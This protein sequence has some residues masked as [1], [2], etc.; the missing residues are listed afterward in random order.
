MTPRSFALAT[1]L[2]ELTMA[3]AYDWLTPQ[4]SD[5]W[6]FP[7]LLDNRPVAASFARLAR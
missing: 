1:D 3:A 6:K 2:Y 4:G 7:K 5:L